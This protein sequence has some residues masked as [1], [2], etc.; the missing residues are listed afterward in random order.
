MIVGRDL[1][2]VTIGTFGIFSAVFIGPIRSSVL[3]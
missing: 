3:R 2:Y 1:I